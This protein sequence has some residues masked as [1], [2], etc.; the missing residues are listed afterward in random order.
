M[1]KVTDDSIQVNIPFAVPFLGLHE[2]TTFSLNR[3]IFQ[4]AVRVIVVVC[5]ALLFW[6]RIKA[7][8]GF[9]DTV[10]EDQTKDI[11]ERIAKL[12]HEKAQRTDQKGKK[13]YAVA[14]GMGSSTVQQSSPV[15]GKT[16]DTGS[17]KKKRG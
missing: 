9:R 5:S 17:A 16:K 8:F 1:A 6:P 11:Q 2:P 15:A 7:A 3:N 13:S 4:T 14:T 10:S 12:E